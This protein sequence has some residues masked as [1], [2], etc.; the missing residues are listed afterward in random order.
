M[1]IFNLHVISRFLVTLIF[2]EVCWDWEFFGICPCIVSVD[3]PLAIYSKCR[4]SDADAWWQDT[5]GSE[6]NQLCLY[7]DRRDYIDIRA[8]VCWRHDFR[9]KSETNGDEATK[10]PLHHQVYA[11]GYQLIWTYFLFHLCAAVW[12]NFN[13]LHL[14]FAFPHFIVSKLTAHER[15]FKHRRLETK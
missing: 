3:L 15:K 5:D 1:D 4:I 11:F 12:P 14:L 6:H 2:R 8:L 7:W 9:L 13:Y 10:L